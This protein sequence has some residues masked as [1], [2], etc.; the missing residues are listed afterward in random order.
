[1]TFTGGSGNDSFDATTLASLND[2]D[3]IDGGDG[4]DTITIK[5]AAGTMVAVH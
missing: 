2:Y 5:I 4:T 3:V 1:M